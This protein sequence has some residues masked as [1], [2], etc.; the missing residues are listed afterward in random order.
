MLANAIDIV[1]DNWLLLLLGQY[2]NGPLG[3]VAHDGVDAVQAVAGLIGGGP[4]QR[5]QQPLGFLLAALVAQPDGRDGGQGHDR[6]QQQR[7]VARRSRGTR[8]GI[9]HGGPSLAWVAGTSHPRLIP[10]YGLRQS[11]PPR[12][13]AT[14]GPARK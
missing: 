8:R 5:R 2:P 12:A 10:R 11:R 4:G 6:D 1:R 7:G 3:G 9:G 13:P 14:P